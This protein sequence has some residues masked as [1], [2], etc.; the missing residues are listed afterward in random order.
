MIPQNVPLCIRFLCG[1]MAMSSVAR[2]DAAQQTAAATPAS[3]GF[4]DVDGGKLYYEE[5]GQGAQTVVLLHDGV[6]DSAVWNEVWPEFCQHFRT[7]RYDRRGFGKS[8][9]TTS[10]Y[11]EIDDLAALF[12]HLG[13]GRV[14]LVGSSHGG[15][16]AID[17][18]LAH[19]DMVQE[20][21]LVGPV[22]SGM[23]YS[24]YFLDRGKQA[25][26]LLQKGD[27]KG[28]TTEWS[29]DK[30]LIEPQND[31]AR[32]KLLELLTANS[33]DLTHEATDMIMARKPAI[34]RLGAIKAPT[35]IITGADDIPD[36]HA[37]AGAIEAG[38]PSARRVVMDGV[39]H[40]LY[41]E[42]PAEFARLA[43]NF[44][45]TNQAS[46]PREEMRSRGD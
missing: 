19:P 6:V 12:H 31:G 38:I 41:L 37:H 46:E 7:I 26:G 24:L 29:K 17:F 15:E 2:S 25:Y 20:L 10:W 45:E 14:A 34:G 39:G 43:I 21:V 44:L 42:K 30:F 35:L 3:T 11:S 27:V 16:L 40:L 8:P 33:Q 13:V 1:L 5:S 32:R 9:P 36:V 23:P 28:A 22:L 18:T 4:V